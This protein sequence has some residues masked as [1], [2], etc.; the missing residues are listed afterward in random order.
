[1][2]KCIAV[3]CL[4][5]AMVTLLTACGKFECEVCGYESTGKKYKRDIAGQEYICCETCNRKLEA[6]QGIGDSL[7][8]IGDSLSDLGNSLG[9]LFG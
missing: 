5:V 1:M 9:S 6:V 3:L 7:N 8:D 2:K 4:V